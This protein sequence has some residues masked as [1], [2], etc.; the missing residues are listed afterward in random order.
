MDLSTTIISDN[1]ELIR[2]VYANRHN[3]SVNSV[4]RGKAIDMLNEFDMMTYGNYWLTDQEERLL[5]QLSDF[6]EALC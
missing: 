1:I 2:Q 5:D 4:S 3:W 6:V